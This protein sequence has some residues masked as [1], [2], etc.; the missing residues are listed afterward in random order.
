[1]TRPRVINE[2]MRTY[3]ERRAKDY[4]DWWLGT[5]KFEERDRPGWS[6]EVERLVGVVSGL[7][8]VRVLDLACGTGFLT[9]HL[10]GD[11]VGIDQSETMLEV[12]AQRVPGARLVKGDA[13]PLPFA[14]GEFERVF[15]S[16][17]YGHLLEA[18]R[19]AFLSEVRRV[20]HELVV[21][22]AALREDVEPD[23]WPE[24]VLNDGTVYRVYKRFFTG[25]GLV[26]E[27]GGGE[28]I[29][30]G[31]WFVAVAAPTS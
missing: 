25:S 19:N 5:G 27:L 4:D 14:E 13:V 21:V 24:R 8:P 15:T 31:R 9:R 28:V 30:D 23:G 20:A 1:V 12:A 6:E 26:T 2:E 18:E 16:H 10:R 3:Y 17:F 7:T 22:D 29:H 11:V